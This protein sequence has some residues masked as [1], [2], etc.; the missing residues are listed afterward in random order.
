[1]RGSIPA[2]AIKH[3]Q[4]KLR[5]HS[6]Y[7][8]NID[9]IRTV[10]TGRSQTDTAIKKALSTRQSELALKPDEKSF[11]DWSDKRRAIGYFQLLLGDMSFDPGPADGFW[12]PR[13]DAAYDLMA[14][15]MGMSWRDEQDSGLIYQPP[16]RAIEPIRN[17]WP[18]QSMSDLSQFYGAPCSVNL[19][20]IEVPWT[21]KLAWDKK[22]RIKTVSVHEKCAE[23]LSRVF[24]E[25]SNTYSPQEIKEYG[26]NLYGGSYNCRKMRGSERMSTHAWGIALDFDPERNQLRWDANKAFLARPELE[27]FWQIWER[28]GWTSLGREKDYDW[29]HVQAA[30]IQ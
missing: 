18:K 22:T 14:G 9:G 12:G 19:A 24:A 11:Y 16:A 25:V 3:I 1:M 6:L 2:Q 26:L 27:P 10:A 8:G 7:Q 20:R 28:E 15:N 17:I 30:V 13:T 29:M 23:S 21:M 5:R 4:L